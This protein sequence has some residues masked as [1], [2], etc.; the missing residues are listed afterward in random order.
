MRS[1]ILYMNRREA[2][3]R[4]AAGA[5][6]LALPEIGIRRTWAHN[7]GRPN[8]ILILADDMGFSDLGC[9]GSEIA[10]PNL[11]R[12]A[13][14]GIRFTQ[15]Y[16][17]ARCCP[18][19]ASLLT[20][21]YP[22]Q[23]GVGHMVQDRGHPAYQGY[24]NDRCV[25]L[26]EALRMGGYHTLMSGKW[27]VGDQQP[28]WPLDRGFDDYFGLINGGSNY[29]KLDEGRIFAIGNTSITDLGD[30]FYM[31]EAF[32]DSA[33]RQIREYA[34]RGKPF[35]QYIAYTAPHWPLHALP[36]DIQKYA[37]RYHAGWDALREERHRRL[38]EM[39]LVDAKWPLT[40][41]DPQAPAWND[42]PH[43]EWEARRM[44]VYAAQIDRMD[45]GV[46]R[47]VATLR[48]LG[49]ENNTLILFLSDNGGC[50]EG[51]PGNDP[52]IMP[53]P[54]ETFQSYGLPWA[55]TS[56]TPFRRYKH[57]VHEG[58]IATPFIAYWPGQI[59]PNTITHQPGHVI[60][61]LPTCLDIA[62]VEYPPAFNGKRIQ[63]LE[64]LSLR[65]VLEGKIRAGHKALFWEHEGNRAVR[66]GKWKLVSKHP[67]EW[68]LYDLEEDRTE[69]NNLIAAHP[70]LAND[71]IV[72]YHRW[73][74]RAG[75]MDWEE[76]T[77]KK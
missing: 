54:A 38:I 31:T 7:N 72:L 32:T 61:I 66:Q 65:P 37:D 17:C 15:F 9:Y 57:W 1:S 71:L 44:A 51:R 3:Q 43:K 52:A 21:L 42:A 41:R 67:E 18:T 46:G 74:E 69:S 20:G 35:F 30:G 23:A 39:G 27:H 62:G 76:L 5:A 25:T 28:H 50:A 14:N 70:A 29:F 26:A 11:D 63:P 68:E 34:G 2:L 6:G 24:L 36:E 22:H 64:G 58:G 55:N 33:V 56:N 49:I 48:E 19:R 45:Q 73:A 10:T 16:N 47:I 13:S 8:I 53:G 12:L 77:K 75:V 59:E 60:D 4:L 40:P